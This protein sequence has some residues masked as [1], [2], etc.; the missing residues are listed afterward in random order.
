MDTTTIYFMAA[1]MIT[2]SSSLIPTTS[3]IEESHPSP[4]TTFYNA[5]TIYPTILIFHPI[6]NY[7]H[8][9][10]HSNNDSH[11]SHKEHNNHHS[12]CCTSLYTS[13]A[14][15]MIMTHLIMMLML[16]KAVMIC[17]SVY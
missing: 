2:S 15:I 10:I 1:I 6:S 8:S 16:M 11:S 9:T 14:M 5:F 12:T 13:Q 17:T 4:S 3:P 7:T